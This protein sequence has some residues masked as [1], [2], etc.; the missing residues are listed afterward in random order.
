MYHLVDREHR[1]FLGDFD[2]RERRRHVSA[3]C[4]RRAYAWRGSS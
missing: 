4:S 3:S 2:T 1:R